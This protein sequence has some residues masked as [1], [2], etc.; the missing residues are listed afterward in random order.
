MLQQTGESVKGLGNI[1]LNKEILERKDKFECSNKIIN[2]LGA[3]NSKSADET[4][5]K[6]LLCTI[7]DDLKR[8]RALFNWLISERSREE[9]KPSL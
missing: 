9:V 5:S 2:A 3:C 7:N 6:K 8:D 1:F 4:L